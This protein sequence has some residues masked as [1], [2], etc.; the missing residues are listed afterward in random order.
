M[1]AEHGLR[2]SQISLNPR[3]DRV[4][5]T[6][7]APCDPARDLE[8]RYRLAE[9]SERGAVVFE[10]RKCV[11]P[12]HFK[13]FYIIF[14]E[15]ASRHGY[16]FLQQRLDFCEALEIHK[17]VREVECCLEGV[18]TLFASELQIS[19][20]YISIHLYAFHRF[21]ECRSF[22]LERIVDA[23][24]VLGAEHNLTVGFRKIY[25][26]ALCSNPEATQSDTQLAIET[27]EGCVRMSRRVMGKTHPRTLEAERLLGRAREQLAAYGD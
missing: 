6:K 13:R 24:R 10:E 19:R 5:A 1:G 26:V 12:P 17:G 20:V 11:K 22:A 16:H 7:H 25:A 21:A 2:L 18:P 9:I 27:L 3:C 15:N 14:A 8:R 4:R 23:E